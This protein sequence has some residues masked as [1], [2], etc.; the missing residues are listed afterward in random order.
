METGDSMVN[1]LLTPTTAARPSANAIKSLLSFFIIQSFVIIRTL[2]NE[3]PLWL[4]QPI[5]ILGK[6]GED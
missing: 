4:V 6:Q 1:V 3:S 2:P 5:R